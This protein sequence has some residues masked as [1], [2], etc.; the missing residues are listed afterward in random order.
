MPHVVVAGK[1]HPSG[2]ALLK[3]AE[4]FTYDYVEEVSEPSYAPLV[5]GA[6]ALVLRTQP[7]SAATVAQAGRLRIVSRHGVGYDAVHLP[8]L[9][10]RGI[11]LA[12]VGD[13]NSVSVAEHAMMLLLALAKRT[14]VADRAVR[15]GDWKW[16]DRLDASEL[17]GKHLLIIGFGRIGRHL[18]RLASRLRHEGD[19]A[20]TI[21]IW[22]GAGLARGA[23]GAE[24]MTWPAASAGPTPFRCMRRRAT[25]R[26]SA[27]RNCAGD[28][29]FGGADQHVAGWRGR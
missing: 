15:T 7:L 3:D 11:A 20:L 18:A 22:S 10:E 25:G 16:R 24:S 19:R 26:P 1:I 28:E 17:A 9:N 12:I 8:S 13:V 6:D 27:R 4:G 21:R 29:A 2:I 23:G 14:N 5:A